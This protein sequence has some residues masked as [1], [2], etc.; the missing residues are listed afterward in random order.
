M[1]IYLS[2]V[3]YSEKM[4]A[5]YLDRDGKLKPFMM[6]CY[7]IGVTRMMSAAIEQLHDEK[8]IIWPPP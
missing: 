1:G 8:G 7:G 2:W 3:K 4:D 5:K 6:G